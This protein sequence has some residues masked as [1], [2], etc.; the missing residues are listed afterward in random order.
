L[1]ARESLISSIND[2]LTVVGNMPGEADHLK[3]DNIFKTYLRYGGFTNDDFVYTQEEYQQIQQQKQ[4]QEQ[5]QQ[6]FQGGMQSAPKLRAEMPPK[7]ALM[8]LVKSAPEGSAAAQALLQEAAK[9][10][11]F[12]TPEVQSAFDAD[13]KIQQFQEQ[14][15]AHSIGHEMG[16]RV[17]EPIGN[18]LQDHPHLLP[19]PPGKEPKPAGG[20]K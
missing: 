1:L 9:V 4:Q 8:E 5:Q 11:G 20:K 13:N 18:P 3:M 10:W 7:D 14:N 6:A 19:P 16:A 2:L 17:H 15:T 12:V